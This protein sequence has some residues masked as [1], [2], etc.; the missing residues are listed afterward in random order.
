MHMRWIP[1]LLVAVVF[2]SAGCGGERL[3]ELSVE[4]ATVQTIAGSE[5][6]RVILSPAAAKRLDIRTSKVRTAAHRRTVIPYSAVLYDPDGRTWT[7]TSLKALTFVRRDIAVER[8]A[9]SRAI[10]TDGPR[11][12]TA[13]VTVGATE[14]W[15]VE[16]G[17]IEED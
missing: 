1:P 14:L 3:N 7:Y 9:G 2:A 12:G 13:V 15:G 4:P 11:P 10:L 17:E 16:Y 6:K 8:V 5:A